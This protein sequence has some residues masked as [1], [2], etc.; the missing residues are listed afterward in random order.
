MKNKWIAW[1]LML[2]LTFLAACS[3]SEV[4]TQAD[5]PAVTSTETADVQETEDVATE[6]ATEVAEQDLPTLGIGYMFSNHQ[7][8][9]IVAATQNTE[10]ESDGAHLKEV[11]PKEKYILNDG[12][13]DVA[14]IDI[15]VAQN[16]GEV[17]TMLTQGQLDLGIAS[18][19]L[20]LTTIDKGHEMKVLGPIHTDGIALVMETDSPLDGFDDFASYVEEQEEPVRVGYHSPANAPVI[21]F[22][23][24][25]TELGFT[26]T[27]SPEE[28][29]ADVLLINLKGTAN[30]IPSLLSNEVQAFIGPS[31]FPEL[32]K[33]QDSGKIIFDLRDLPPEGEW[34]NFPCCVFS[35]NQTALDE[36]PEIVEAFY[37]VLTT[38]SH[39]AN[40]NQ[41]ETGKIVTEW[42]GVDEEAA[43]NTITH[44]TTDADE[45]WMKNVEVTFDSLQQTGNFEGSLLDK[46]FEEIQS[47]VIDLTIEEKV[48]R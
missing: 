41:E 40:E 26:V 29:D 25:M 8:P 16:G 35:A 33:V 18:I 30:L 17:M 23:R 12:E 21:L 37:E 1:G 14:N 34:H 36:H 39:F 24:A 47:D 19:G 2:I 20:P 42:M 22:T 43:S 45:N 7:T 31:P 48:V 5:E 28:V 27:E 6:E 4:S 32:A 38:A 44:F 13:K 11:L 46:T 10:F 3:S 9:L 15:V